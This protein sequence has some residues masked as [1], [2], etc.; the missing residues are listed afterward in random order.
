MSHKEVLLY[1]RLYAPDYFKFLFMASVCGQLRNQVKL[2]YSDF[3]PSEKLRRKFYRYSGFVPLPM[4]RIF[5]L[6][7]ALQLTSELRTR[8]VTSRL[9][10]LENIH[11][12]VASENVSGVD[13][14][15]KLNSVFCIF[16]SVN[17]LFFFVM[18][19]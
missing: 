18:S 13:K 12:F 10:F 1:P 8:H 4:R 6:T 16:F 7:G 5:V 9:T 14:T 3:L 19:L 17:Y 2:S 15:A 11:D